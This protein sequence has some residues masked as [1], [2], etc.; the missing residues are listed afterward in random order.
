LT[1]R[2]A[3]LAMAAAGRLL[4]GAKP[5]GQWK[6]DQRVDGYV[7]RAQPDGTERDVLVA[8]T[9]SGGFS[10]PSDLSVKA[11]FDCI[12]RP[13]RARTLGDIRLGADPVFVLLAKGAGEKLSLTPPPKDAEVR[14]GEAST[15]VLQ[16]Y[17]PSSRIELDKSLYTIASSRE[18]I[19]VYAY[20]FGDAPVHGSVAVNAPGD[21]N[22]SIPAEAIDIKP[23]ERQELTLHVT[24]G[25][26]EV[27]ALKITG[28]FGAAGHPMVSVRLLPQE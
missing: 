17:L 26:T 10:V 2:P 23:G 24:P 11:A 16:A 14:K 1:P 18:R 9:R 4:A 20:N 21:W 28:D 5:V 27:Q 12:G 13:I 25:G 22:A 6:P 7:F 19:T 15:V 3:Y 8:W